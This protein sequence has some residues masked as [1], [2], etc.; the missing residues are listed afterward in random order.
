MVLATTRIA[1]CESYSCI[2]ITNALEAPIELGS[3]SISMDQKQFPEHIK[4]SP[5]NI[6]HPITTSSSVQGGSTY[7]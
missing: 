4:L 6:S 7:W 1:S 2:A 3:Y 5:Q